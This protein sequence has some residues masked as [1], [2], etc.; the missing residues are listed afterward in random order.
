VRG[1]VAEL[2][3]TLPEDVSIFITSDDA[4]FI[5]GAI[6]EVLKT[7]GL[8]VM[9]VVVVIFVFLRDAARHADPGADDAR[10]ADRH[11]CGDLARGLLGQHPDAARAGAGHRHGRRRRDRRAGEHRAPPGEGMGPRAA[12]VLGTQQVFFAVVTT[13]ATLAAVFVPLSFLP[14]QAG[15]LFRE[16]GFTLAMAVMLSSVVALTLCP[17]WPAVAARAARTGV[18]GPDL[19]REPARE[20]STA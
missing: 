12:A 17:C 14:G 19:A 8:A 1:I 20:R 15:G 6:E 18:A 7:L 4:V 3:A 2:Q 11:A 10:G 13:T 9:I 5:R 16:F